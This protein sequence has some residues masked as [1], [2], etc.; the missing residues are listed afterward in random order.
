MLGSNLFK[1]MSWTGLFRAKLCNSVSILYI[2]ERV[3]VIQ[4]DYFYTLLLNISYC[5]REPTECL[6][7]GRG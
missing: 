2:V 5:K 4:V 3:H 6:F 1:T 7:R